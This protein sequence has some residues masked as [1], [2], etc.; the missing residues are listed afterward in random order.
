M[1][2]L[3]QAVTEAW[4]L[5][6][7]ERMNELRDDR[8]ARL[9]DERGLHP[10]SVVWGKIIYLEQQQELAVELDDSY[11]YEAGTALPSEL[12]D[13]AR[14]AASRD[15]RDEILK[16]DEDAEGMDQEQAAAT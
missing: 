1:D 10:Y 15:Y 11:S 5:A 3:V 13:A 8:R 16:G 2:P 6:Y 4:Q 14:A 7:G 12:R 9:L